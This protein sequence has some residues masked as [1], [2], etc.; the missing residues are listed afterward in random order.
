MRIATN[1]NG[2]DRGSPLLT[3]AAALVAAQVA[4]EAASAIWNIGVA[5]AA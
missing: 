2:W 3:V 1:T 4:K 5:P